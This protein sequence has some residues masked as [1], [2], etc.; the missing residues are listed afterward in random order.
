MQLIS[1]L[2]TTISVLLVRMRTEYVV[3]FRALSADHLYN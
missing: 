3:G 1:F 2:S